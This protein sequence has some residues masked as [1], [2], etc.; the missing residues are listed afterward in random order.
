MAALDP[1]GELCFQRH[2]PVLVGIAYQILGSVFD[3]EDTV[4]DAWLRWS[5]VDRGQV[6]DP[7]AYLVTVTTRLAIDRLRRARVRRETYVGTWLPEPIA[8]DADLA[9]HAGLAEHVEL[10]VLVVLETLSPV[11]RAVFVLREA[12]GLRYREIA[13]VVERE[14]ATV[15]QIAR[16]AREDVA[17]RRPR[18][19]TDGVRRREITRRFLHACASGELHALVALLATDAR[20]TT[21][22][23]GRAKAPRRPLVGAHKI[24]RF[25]IAVAPLTQPPH[26]D[27]RIEVREV[28]GGPAIVFTEDQ[29]PVLLIS[30]LPAGDLVREIYLLANPEKLAALSRNLAR[31][32]SGSAC[33]HPSPSSA[34]AWPG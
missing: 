33:R 31:D 3:A 8:T 21:D 24:A 23:G 6:A 13:E 4:Q 16:R 22:N 30:L 34:A 11:Q 29:T 5:R 10:A 12:F 9:E 26:R 32:A 1:T 7:K 17:A 25:L 28:N 14:E 18:F 15:R 20:L 27:L 2:R 19:E